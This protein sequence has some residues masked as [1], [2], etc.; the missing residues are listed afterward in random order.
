MTGV[1]VAL[2]VGAVASTAAAAV[3]TIQA[4]QQRKQASNAAAAAQEYNA[5]EQRGLAS[6]QM[7]NADSEA[8]RLEDQNRRRLASA[9]NAFGATGAMTGS[10]SA[11]DVSADLAAESALDA[12]ILRWRGSQQSETT[13]RQA[14]IG[15]WEAGITRQAGKSAASAANVQA[16]ANLL[17]SGARIAAPYAK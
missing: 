1:E 8:S 16:G 17:A 5:A 14:G 6:R 2:V 15:V 10:G 4:G 13:A 12:E 9:A 3:G 11:L 7:A